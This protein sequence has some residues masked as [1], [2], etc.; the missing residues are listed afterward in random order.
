MHK[1]KLRESVRKPGSLNF[2]LVMANDHYSF[3]FFSPFAY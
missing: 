1:K 2:F 3:F